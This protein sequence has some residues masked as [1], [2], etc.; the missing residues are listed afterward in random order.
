MKTTIVYKID[1]LYIP[2]VCNSSN[3]FTNGRTGVLSSK[4]SDITFGQSWY[5]DGYS[6]QEFLNQ[7]EFDKLQDG[8]ERCIKNIVEQVLNLSLSNFSLPKYHHFIKTNQ[9]HMKVVRRTRDLFPVDFNFPVYSLIAAIEESLGFSLTDK[10]EV[11]G[12]RMHIIIRINRPGSHDYNPPHKDI[13]GSF[14][15]DPENAEKFINLWIPICGVN[16][17]TSLPI[18]PCS[19]LIDESLIVRT[20]EGADLS[21]GKYRV[22]IIK[23]WNRSSELT[24]ADVGER[25][26][27]MF[28]PFLIHG[29]GYNPSD[30]ES[31]VS[32]EFR[33]LRA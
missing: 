21:G 30:T 27:L 8:V 7:G 19:H 1:D 17:R 12:K 33:L 11:M 22:N 14:D 4:E 13:Y 31:R 32:L 2:V 28:S 29:L 16:K 26:V 9:E 5:P 6:V 18:V 3:I 25:E 24:R 20:T 23:E 15:A 10:S